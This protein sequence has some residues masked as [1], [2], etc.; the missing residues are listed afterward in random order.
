M[1]PRANANPLNVEAN[2]SIST[3][4]AYSRIVEDTP[5]LSD[6]ELMSVQELKPSSTTMLSQC[7]I[8][9]DIPDP[10]ASISSPT[11][12]ISLLTNSHAESSTRATAL[13]GPS[14][15][16]M[17]DLEALNRAIESA[18]ATKPSFSDSI[19]PDVIVSTTTTVTA[20]TTAST[21]NS[22]MTSIDSSRHALKFKIKGP[23]LDA[24][25]SG[26]SA[27]NASNLPLSLNANSVTSTPAAE[28]SN[29]RRMRK[30]EL[31]RQY[32]SQ[33]VTTPTQPSHL[34]AFLH[35]PY[36][37][38]L[39]Y[40]NEEYLL[41]GSNDLSEVIGSTNIGTLPSSSNLGQQATGFNGGKNHISI[42]KAVA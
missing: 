6:R 33:D 16:A 37:S 31:I 3:S 24:N 42:P 10:S 23:F 32:V 26:Y 9:E 20:V 1:I 34:N 18:L 11:T 27:G 2:L 41:A 7:P 29:L 17:Q 19:K 22:V 4:A 14:V 8:E 38:A 15:K 36:S 30:K 40:A 13:P 5:S 12:G 21:C 25:Y 28:S 39:A 35:F